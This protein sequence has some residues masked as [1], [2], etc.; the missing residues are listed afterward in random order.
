MGNKNIVYLRSVEFKLPNVLEK[1][2]VHSLPCYLV[3]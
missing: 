2:K 1:R 3:Y